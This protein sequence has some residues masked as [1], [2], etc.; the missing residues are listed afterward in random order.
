MNKKFVFFFFVCYFHIYNFVGYEYFNSEKFQK[1]G[2]IAKLTL[3]WKELCKSKKIFNLKGESYF[4][5]NPKGK[6]YRY[7]YDHKGDSVSF[8]KK[9]VDVEGLIARC[10]FIPNKNSFSGFFSE[11]N[12]GFIRVS[13]AIPFEESNKYNYH[14]FFNNFSKIYE[15]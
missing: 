7:L 2:R 13:T 12:F 8:S 4:T 6:Y 11:T 10:K 1:K 9:R 3:L 14:V 5:T 15:G